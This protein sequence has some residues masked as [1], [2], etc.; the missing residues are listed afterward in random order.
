MT[1]WALLLAVGVLLAEF[2]A[3]S[4]QAAA[5]P[6]RIATLAVIDGAIGPAT[7]R[8]FT[9]ALDNAAQQHHTLVILQLDTPGGLDSSMRDIIKAILA[10][11]VPV[12]SFVA[13]S[14]AR[15]ASAGTYILYASHVAA[16]A[17]ATNLGAATPVAIGGEDNTP[18]PTGKQPDGDAAAAV[19]PTTMERK[20]VND[21][22][23]Y[24]RSLAQLRGRNVDWAEKAV[25]DAA[26]LPSNEAL[27]QHVIDLVAADIPDLLQQLHGRRLT[28]ADQDI[29]LDTRNLRVQR[30][31]PDWRTQ[32]LSVI[33][34]PTIA[35]GLMLIGI[36]GLLLEGYNPG[37][38]LPGVAGAISL[39]V[40][41]Y[42]FQLLSVNYA[43]LGL[44][45]LGIGLMIAE[46]FV[47]AFGSLL[48]GG[49]IAFVL[50]SIMMF[51]SEVPGLSVARPVIAA[52]ATSGALLAVGIVVLATRSQRRP[53][54]TGVET[55][56]G[57]V[58]EV[59]SDFSSQGLVRC[60][61]ELWQ[62]H[63]EVPMRAGQQV[64][65]TKVDGL[66]L[67]VRSDEGTH[68]EQT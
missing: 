2:A 38:I 14:G 11:P 67:S 55:M 54:S 7:S 5:P 39:L 65:V 56:V 45:A 31:E 9:G 48:I 12:V 51:D 3:P 62:A 36:Y 34:H 47:S 30:V 33:T 10:S 23:S 66:V 19:Q 22:V 24:I 28:V 4:E 21:A 6:E 52:I 53:I 20:S 60:D 61:G 44:I 50:G 63:A 18:S 25:R 49:L 13:P 58:V 1:R 59:V 37:A 27:Q 35:Y 46:I 57:T 29:V 43:G 17:P 8:Y 64:R 32:F 40:A 16:M 42:A 41:L 68:E 26:S 15:A